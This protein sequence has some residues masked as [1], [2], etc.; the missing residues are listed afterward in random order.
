MPCSEKI[1]AQLYGEGG[2]D[3][4]GKDGNIHYPLLCDL[5]RIAYKKPGI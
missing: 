1:S 4:K 3:A 5:F 2:E